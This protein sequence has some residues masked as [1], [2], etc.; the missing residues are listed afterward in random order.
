MMSEIPMFSSRSRSATLARLVKEEDSRKPAT[1]ISPRS[2]ALT[3]GTILA[4]NPEMRRLL[5][6]HLQVR[7][8]SLLHLFRGA[9]SWEAVLKIQGYLDSLDQL[10]NDIER[11]DENADE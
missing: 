7:K 1:P 3:M 6:E 8:E 5:M 2:K 9:A 4:G 11:G 10:M